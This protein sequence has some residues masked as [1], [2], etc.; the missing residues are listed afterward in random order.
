MEIEE[1]KKDITPDMLQLLLDADP[2]P[3]AIDESIKESTIFVARES[4]RIVG[5]VVLKSSPR[6]CE[7]KSISVN[8]EYR[9]KG[10]GGQLIA[11]ALDFC[12]K[13]H[14]KNIIVGTGNSSLEQL[15]FY[16]KSGFRIFD[17]K[18]GHFD[19]YPEAIFENGIQC[20]DLVLLKREL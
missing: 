4:G 15:R 20:R 18:A 10:I 5:V 7:I 14:A 17:V 13:L 12:R 6:E 19:K 8:E 1:Y 16:Q 3:E 11:K 2:S 9:N